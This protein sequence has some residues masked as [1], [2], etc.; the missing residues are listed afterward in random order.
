[1]ITSN[2]DACNKFPCDNLDWTEN[3]ISSDIS[4]MSIRNYNKYVKI[5]SSTGSLVRKFLIIKASSKSKFSAQTG[6]AKVAQ[7]YIYLKI[8]CTK[9]IAIYFLPSKIA[10]LI[11]LF[12]QLQC[13]EC[14]ECYFL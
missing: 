5:N 9:S 8:Q 11:C 7:P 14:R 3:T 13:I 2:P 4:D 12:Q 10:T 6:W 1:M